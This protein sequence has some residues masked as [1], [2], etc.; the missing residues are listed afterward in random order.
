MSVVEVKRT[1][2][3]ENG[4]YVVEVIMLS[5]EGIEKELMVYQGDAFDHVAT[6]RDI[7]LY[8]PSAAQAEA[9]GL[10]FHR[11][12]RVRLVYSTPAQAREAGEHVEGR[13]S[14]SRQ[15][16]DAQQPPNFGINQTTVYA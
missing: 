12:D 1:E 5:A 7:A 9:L 16:Y 13:I 14:T 8:P 2:S 3:V 11:R 6:P 10:A 15:L 4:V